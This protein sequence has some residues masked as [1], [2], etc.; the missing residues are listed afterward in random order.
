[1][2]CLDEYFTEVENQK[3]NQD[4]LSKVAARI[5]D[6]DGELCVPT[7]RLLY[8]AAVPL[9]RAEYINLDGPPRKVPFKTD[10][11]SDYFFLFNDVLLYT[12]A[13]PNKDV[14]KCKLALP[15]GGLR[16]KNRLDAQTAKN[17]VTLTA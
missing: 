16:L 2:R 8:E 15:V 11:E 9:T 6:Y 14:F 12:H 10:Q 5:K 3:F 13:K 17:H 7:R 4:T 1:M